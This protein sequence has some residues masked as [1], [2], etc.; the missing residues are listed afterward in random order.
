[1]KRSEKGRKNS[2]I[3]GKEMK[4]RRTIS[5][6]AAGGARSDVLH[7]RNTLKDHSYNPE[8]PALKL[9]SRCLR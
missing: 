6:L 8:R 9:N 3:K 5:A 7:I 1:M 4:K 2:K